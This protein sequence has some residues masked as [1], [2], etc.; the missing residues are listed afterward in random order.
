MSICANWGGSGSAEAT[1]SSSSD[2]SFRDRRSLLERRLPMRLLLESRLP[3]RLLESWLPMRLL[4]EG[5]ALRSL[6]ASET[7]SRA[8]I[9]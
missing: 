5:E 3:M 7:R 6:Q 4:R 9:F 2:G 8:E 1:I